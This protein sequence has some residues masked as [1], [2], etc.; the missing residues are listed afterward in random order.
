MIQLLSHFGE[1]DAPDYDTDRSVIVNWLQSQVS[2]VW[3]YKM[4]RLLSSLSENVWRVHDI[5]M[6]RLMVN[7]LF[8][9]MVGQE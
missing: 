7:I 5:H 3:P 2:V 6:E 8:C 9:I 4:L 1:Y